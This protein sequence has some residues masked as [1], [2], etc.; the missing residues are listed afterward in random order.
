MSL[1]VV[2]VLLWL[3]WLA[4][5]PAV[6][7]PA[8]G[9]DAIGTFPNTGAGSIET[10]PGG[11]RRFRDSNGQ[12][13]ILQRTPESGFPSTQFIAPVAPSLPPS[14]PSTFQ[15]PPAPLAPSSSLQQSVPTVPG[16]Q[17]PQIPFLPGR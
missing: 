7:Q 16:T 9:S 8:S 12:S 11:F 3:G 2:S 10:L 14:Q 5:S 17:I 1:M 15:A 13:G 4:P 6:A